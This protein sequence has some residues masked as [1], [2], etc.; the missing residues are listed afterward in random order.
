MKIKFVC[1]SQLEIQDAIP[2]VAKAKK[3]RVPAGRA[4]FWLLKIDGKLK[5]TSLCG[6]ALYDVSPKTLIR[7]ARID[8]LP[9]CPKCAEAWKKTPSK[10]MGELAKESAS[11]F[12]ARMTEAEEIILNA[13]QAK[14]AGLITRQQEIDVLVMVEF[15][16][17]AQ[18][19]D[20]EETRQA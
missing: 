4:H 5:D 16:E 20:Y 13:A 14:S 10:R 6:L 2:H 1:E 11:D 19:L 3:R 8:S 12:G 7:D 18:K 17:L 9:V 15:S